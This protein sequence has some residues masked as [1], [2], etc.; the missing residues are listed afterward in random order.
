MSNARQALYQL[1]KKLPLAIEKFSW[2]DPNLLLGGAGWHI[3]IT[4]GWRIVS[5]DRLLLG[6]D[7]ATLPSLQTLISNSAIVEC[8]VQS[9]HCGLD[10]A[11]VLDNGYILEIFS[12]SYLEPW[13]MQIFETGTFVSSPSE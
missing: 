6:S 4:T 1:Q 8:E 9:Q 10:P 13:V 12:S 5:A 2:N 11:L 7:H 3:S